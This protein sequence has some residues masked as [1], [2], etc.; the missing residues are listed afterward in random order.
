MRRCLIAFTILMLAMAACSPGDRAPASGG[1]VKV[2]ATHSILGD[3]VSNVGGDLV[4]LIILVGPGQD[5]HAYEPT[6]ANGVVLAQASLIFENGWGFETWMDDLYV[7]SGSAAQRVVTA[8]TIEPLTGE[9]EHEGEH[10]E[11]EPAEEDHGEFD[12]HV[13]HSVENARQ[14]VQVIAG[15]LAQADPA[16]AETYQAN[17]AGYSAELEQLDA[18][19]IEQVETIP[20][21][22]RK[23]VTTHDTFGYFAQRYGFEVVGTVLPTSTE[24]ASPSAQELATL[25]EAVKAEGVPAVF[26]ENVSSNGL[27]NQVANEAGVDLVVSLYTDALGPPGSEADTYIAMMRY[28]VTTIASALS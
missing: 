17:A 11:G 5:T 20:E 8:S 16:N 4:E 22:N 18:W 3:L 7:S 21:A 27:L 24:S 1:K 14:M 25:V 28:N 23:P 13:W 12:P 9:E 19:V 6:A 26:A 2:V 15:A 10:S